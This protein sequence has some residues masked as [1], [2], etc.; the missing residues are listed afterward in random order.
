[1]N[2][3]IV[4]S[5][6][7]G[8]FIGTI[9]FL[10]TN[11]F[12]IPK[13]DKCGLSDT[14]GGTCTCQDGQSCISNNCVDQIKENLSI[15]NLSTITSNCTDES[16]QI[17]KNGNCTPC[18]LD[19]IPYTDGACHKWPHQAKGVDIDWNP[20]HCIKKP[21]MGCTDDGNDMFVQGLC[22]PCCAGTNSYLV[23]DKQCTKDANFKYF[24]YSED[25]AANNSTRNVSRADPPMCM[26]YKTK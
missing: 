5:L 25:T 3:I 19:M 9:I 15:E 8:I 26:P 16:D 21:P 20:P 11:F 17:M 4:L 13:C 14:C 2:N 24:C 10:F 23:S 1:M 12:C 22:L 6:I 18:C 7:I